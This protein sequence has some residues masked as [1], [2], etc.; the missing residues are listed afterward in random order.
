MKK[1]VMLA[2]VVVAMGIEAKVTPGTPFADG[3]VLQ[4]GR[5]VPVWGWADPGAEVTVT[6][7]GQKLKAK[8]GAD[9]K[10]RVDL[11]PMEAS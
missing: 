4:R 3:M 2:A 5:N 9:G 8:A 11:A 6:F 7:A 1:L 10:W